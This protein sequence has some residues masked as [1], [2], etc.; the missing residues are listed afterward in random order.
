MLSEQT[1][2]FASTL[3]TEQTAR[4][5]QKVE[6]PIVKLQTSAKQVRNCIHQQHVPSCQCQ[7][8][9]CLARPSAVSLKAIVAQIYSSSPPNQTSQTLAKLHLIQLRQI[10]GRGDMNVDVLRG[11]TFGKIGD[12]AFDQA[13]LSLDR[14]CVDQ[15]AS[16]LRL[17]GDVQGIMVLWFHRF[18]PIGCLVQVAVLLL[19]GDQAIRE[20]VLE[21]PGVRGQKQA[22]QQLRACETRV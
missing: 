22:I 3:C 14:S 9:G 8:Q 20:T 21:R 17:I 11:V 13:L 6:P 19:Q 10:D 12:R 16:L 2:E 5:H 1:P 15:H 4:L 18:C 7:P